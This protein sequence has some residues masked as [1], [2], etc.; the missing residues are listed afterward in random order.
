MDSCRLAPGERRSIINRTNLTATMLV[1]MP[2]P[3]GGPPVAATLS[4]RP[5]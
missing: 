2:Y 4:E 1:I 3:E 5:T